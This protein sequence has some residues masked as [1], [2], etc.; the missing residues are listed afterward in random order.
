MKQKITN[1]TLIINKSH[2]LL[3]LIIT[4]VI[5]YPWKQNTA[6]SE[7]KSSLTACKAAA[8]KVGICVNPNHGNVAIANKL[9]T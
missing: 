7:T 6:T 1:I 9:G 3:T 2:L 4:Y 8:V 5:I